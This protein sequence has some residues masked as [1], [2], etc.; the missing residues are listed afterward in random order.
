M[1]NNDYIFISKQGLIDLEGILEARRANYYRNRKVPTPEGMERLKAKRL[2]SFDTEIIK[3]ILESDE[4]PDYDDDLPLQ[5]QTA[6]LRSYIDD[7][8][9][10]QL[11]AAEKAE[12]H[13][14]G[15]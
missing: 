5:L 4:I 13:K 11:D 9:K 8:R 3:P 1:L 6:S 14:E 15:D 7:L 2:D 12:G 10:L